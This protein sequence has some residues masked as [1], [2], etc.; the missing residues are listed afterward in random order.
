MRFP[1]DTYDQRAVN[2]ALSMGFTLTN[3]NIDPMDYTE[4]MT[5]DQVVA[6]YVAQF[7]QVGAGL[8]RYISLHH[9]IYPLYQD[10][11]VISR[12][13]TTVRSWGYTAVTL[14]DCLSDKAYRDANNAPAGS[15]VKAPPPG[16]P[17]VG[18]PG[19][20]PIGGTSNSGSSKVIAGVSALFA[21]IRALV[22]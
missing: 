10:P 1:F 18:L 15:T 6:P 11:G 16:A 9:D 21:A 2:I 7:S 4:G 13:G 5:P 20:A 17:P 8:G 14:A 19:S 12:V 22:M 3:W